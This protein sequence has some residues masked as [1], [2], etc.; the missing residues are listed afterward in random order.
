MGAT[1]RAV[2]R[3]SRAGRLLAALVA[4][5]L[6]A[7]A[8]GDDD[9]DSGPQQASGSSGTSETTAAPEPATGGTL[10]FA[11]SLSPAG[12]DPVNSASASN[13]NGDGFYFYA[14][15]DML[16]YVDDTTG[17]VV[18][19]TAASI[20]TEDGSVWTLKLRDGIRFSDG[21]PYDA[22][23][24]KF[25]FERIADPAN[26]SSQASVAQAIETAAVIDPLTLELTL[27]RPD[28]RFDRI[29]ATRIPWVGSPTAIRERG[30]GFAEA[31]VGAG[32]F[33]FESWV[34]DSVMTF[35]RNPDYWDEGKLLLDALEIRFIE[36]A[37]QRFNSLT[38]GDVDVMY[39]HSNYEN[40]PRIEEADGL[41]LETVDAPGGFTLQMNTMRPPFDD[42]V[43]RRAVDAAIDRDGLNETVDF[44]VLP[45]GERIYEKE[46]PLYDEDAV[47]GT[48]DPGRAQ[49]LLDQYAQAHGGPLTFTITSAESQKNVMEYL[50][51]QFTEFDNVQVGIELVPPLQAVDRALAHD[52]D[53]TIF[54]MNWTD[55]EPDV[56]NFLHSTGGRN[57]TGYSN[58]E[59][60]A[61]IEAGRS[62]RDNEARAEAYSRVHEILAEDVPF[63]WLRPLVFFHGRSEDVQN[64]STFNSGLLDWAQIG[65]SG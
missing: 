56:S 43:A 32:P 53:A 26:A 46:H 44:G 42:P 17:E 55:P 21:T 20:T 11:H 48:Y 12:M 3:R 41:V 5:T 61:A 14:V 31:P 22:E 34:R 60:D 18:P 29:I 54:T 37:G 30:A 62:T 6:L 28:L 7:A 10:V 8:C 65:L 15:F 50:Q 35:T 24:V 59:M 19:K 40:A 2:R 45:L 63:T 57:Y 1:T 25:N 58:P 39:V 23:A 52:F 36:N 13:A 9:D 49:E 27:K 4:A 16:A 38:T 64:F 51:A 33:L 47:L